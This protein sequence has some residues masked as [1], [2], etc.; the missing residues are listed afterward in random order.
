MDKRQSEVI[1]IAKGICIIL[2]VIGHTMIP[3]I[4]NEYRIVFQIWSVIYLFH[5]PVF[6]AISGMLYELNYD[7]YTK[8][9]KGF[10]KKNLS[11]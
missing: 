2:V 4:R 7:R 5:M 10:L 3:S 11:F 1:K 6:F 8:V 9:P